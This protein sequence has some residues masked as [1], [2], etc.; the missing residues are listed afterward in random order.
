MADQAARL[1]ELAAQAQAGAKRMRVIAVTSGKGGT[2]KTNIV[3]N[4][5]LALGMQQQR[6]IIFDAD[7]GLANVD[8]LAGIAPKFTLNEFLAGEKSMAEILVEIPYGVRVISGGS[9]IGELVN[10]NP[11]QQKRLMA[12]L[13]VFEKDTDYLFIDTGAG[14]SR[15]VLSFLAAAKEVIVVLNP[16]PASLTDAYAVVKILSRFH[17][18]ETFYLI[19][20]RAANLAEAVE[21]VEKFTAVAGRFLA[22]K[23]RPLG[24]IFSDPFVLKA[25]KSQQPLLLLYPHSPAARSFREIAA[26]LRTGEMRSPQGVGNFLQRLLR[27]L[28]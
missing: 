8:V 28:G 5:A 14:I 10:L 4:L 27:F 16:E 2:G 13:R 21:T 25:V 23:L 11:S 24:Y 6:V 12:G 19:V 9:G 3:L 18:H 20:N 26:N 22:V 7:L 1:R 17:L 15:V